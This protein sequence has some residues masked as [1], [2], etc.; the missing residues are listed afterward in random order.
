[1]RGAA[2]LGRADLYGAF[3]RLYRLEVRLDSA[4]P[5]DANLFVVRLA[6]T[7]EQVAR[8]LWKFYLEAHPDYEDAE[9]VVQRHNFDRVRQM[10]WPEVVAASRNISSVDD[11]RSILDQIGPGYV[12]TSKRRRPWTSSS[13]AA[14]ALYT[15]RR[16]LTST[17]AS[18]MRRSRR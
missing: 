12:W 4:D 17:C 5:D 1:M 10:T 11:L 15:A 2:S 6:T 7:V 3:L 16:M 8:R 9:V 18:C 13:P 14:T